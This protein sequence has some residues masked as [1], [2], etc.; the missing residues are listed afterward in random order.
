MAGQDHVTSDDLA[1]AAGLDER[2]VRE[3]LAGLTVGG[4]V[5]HDPMPAPTLYRP[6]TPSA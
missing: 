5:E 2:Y 3:W 6:S 1:D 4:I